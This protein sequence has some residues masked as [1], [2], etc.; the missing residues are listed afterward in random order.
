MLCC[1]VLC[2]AALL[3]WAVLRCAVRW[4]IALVKRLCMLAAQCNIMYVTH[5]T[6][7]APEAVL[8][9]PDYLLMLSRAVPRSTARGL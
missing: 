6:E 5:L 2:C 3:Y 9:L 4:G 1:A 7:L 8:A